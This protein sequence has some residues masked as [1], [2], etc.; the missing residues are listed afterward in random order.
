MSEPNAAVSANKLRD[1]LK[2]LGSAFWIVVAV[3]AL[4]PV[5]GGF[6]LND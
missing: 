3:L 6:L 5:V 1:F 2:E 4:L